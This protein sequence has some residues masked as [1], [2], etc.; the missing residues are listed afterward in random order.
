VQAKPLAGTH[1][2]TIVCG[3]PSATKDGGRNMGIAVNH[4]LGLLALS[5]ESSNDV[6]LFTSPSGDVVRTIGGKGAKR[7]KFLAPKKLCFAPNGN[8]LVA[9][10]GNKRVQELTAAGECVACLGVGA[11]TEG[12]FGITTDGTSV[13][14][15][16]D[17]HRNK[18]VVMDYASD[19]SV[20]G[21]FG[22]FGKEPGQLNGCYGACIT[23]DG[24]HVQLTEYGNNRVSVFTL[25]GDFVK[26]FGSGEM[27]GPT[28]VTL[29]SHCNVVVTS[30][31]DCSVVMFSQDGSR[32]L[33]RFGSESLFSYPNALAFSNRRLYVLD[34]DASVVQVFK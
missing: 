2:A 22:V 8:I 13:V 21:L 33:R 24:V 12:V 23:R 30:T 18:I 3:I 27:F 14:V 1:A 16:Q 26:C 4:D 29:D 34:R 19:R 11:I 17:G 5:C 10:C 15:T 6:K 28:D 25:T 9:D 7:G 32:V 20:R 31:G